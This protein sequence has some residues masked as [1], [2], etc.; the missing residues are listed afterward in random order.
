MDTVLDMVTFSRHT[1]DDAPLDAICPIARDGGDCYLHGKLADW[2]KRTRPGKGASAKVKD[3]ALQLRCT[4]CYSS[5]RLRSPVTAQ[6]TEAIGVMAECLRL[7]FLGFEVVAFA[8]DQDV[9]VGQLVRNIFPN[10]VECLD[11]SHI[12]VCG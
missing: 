3:A 2:A 10:A 11:R 7:Q 5:P 9:G 4:N 6:S 1:G 12:Q 8:H